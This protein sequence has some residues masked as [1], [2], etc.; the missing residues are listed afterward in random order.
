MAKTAKNPY[1]LD[2][3]LTP[4]VYTITLRPDLKNFTFSGKESVTFKAQKPFSKITLHAAELKIKKAWLCGGKLKAELPAKKISYNEKFETAVFDFGRSVKPGEAGCLCIEFD[5]TLNDKL[6]GFY[7][8]AYEV[9]GE[10]RWGAATQFE[11]TDA[12]RAFPC[13]DEPDFKA[14]FKISL[15]VP[16]E[17]TALSNMP[18]EKEE[19]QPGGL[20]KLDYEISPVM[21][22]Y[23][24]CMVVADLEF[25]E[26]KDK[27]GVPIRIYTVPGK[28]EQ[29]RFALEVAQHC[30]PYFGEWFGIPYMLPK[31]DMVSLPDFASGAME[32][33]GLIT[34]RETA[35]LVDPVNSSAAAR[36]R[37]AEVIDHELAHQWF[38]NLVTME[39]WTDLWLN[40]GFASYM[41]P[42]AV[43]DKFPE[44]KIWD[45]FIVAD[46]L[47]ALGSDALRNTHPIEIPVQDP[48]EIREIFDA[49]TYSKGSSVN[50]M[51]EH[52]LGESV[53][54]KGLRV[55]MKKFAYK[56]ASTIDLW[57]TLEQVSGKPVRA[58]MTNFTRQPGFPVL[59]VENK[60]GSTTQFKINQ[61]RFLFD[62]SK[63]AARTRWQVPLVISR[64]GE[65][66]P[67]IGLLKSSSANLNLGK[68]EGWTKINAG[69]SGF[70]RT[71]YS[72]E[73]LAALAEALEDGSL[74]DPV[75]DALGIL[76]DAH[77]LT[78]AGYLKTSCLLDLLGTVKEEREYN[79]WSIVCGSLNSIDNLL[80]GEEDR[81]RLAAFARSLLTPCL[82]DIGWVKRDSD[83]HSTLLLRS[84][85]IS[86]A[87]HFGAD[88]VIREARALFGRF[89]KTGELEPNLR[90]PV[91]AL[92]AENGGEAEFE[93]LINIYR[94]TK[95]QEEKVRVL[96]ALT[97]FKD[98]HAA[99]KSLEFALSKEVR[100]QDTYN[101]LGGYGSS[102]EVRHQAW[103]FV[104][105]N[106]K[107]LRARYEGGSVAS[108]LGHILEGSVT[109]FNK[110]EELKD[111]ETFFKKNPVAGVERT[112]K[113][114]LEIIRSNIRWASRGSK[115]ASGW[116]EKE[117][118]TVRT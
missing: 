101:V 76:S 75:I 16:Q 86:Q 85:L 1:R 57:K 15:V 24:V 118:L 12:R 70:Y 94:G 49:I 103:D 18:V 7:R 71:A 93:A 95:L 45:Q 31:C 109:G 106:F 58:I 104:K 61:E 115:E 77:A 5:G 53:F 110:P 98:R 35:L 28:K 64:A 14:R 100:N 87:G 2:R 42:K 20:K 89:N 44:W 90:G 105:S 92:T 46:Y 26:G 73:M 27:N 8:T 114:S 36:Q 91:Y 81:D 113:Q 17:L 62:G 47:R 82:D 72:A 111:V 33:W 29:G 97:R 74:P 3:N 21:S 67:W 10:K 19:K 23:L 83:S 66:K 48:A 68:G 65:K 112:M 107:E 55:Y 60:K 6:H 41:G 80:D 52:Y 96:R 37:V 108:L 11:A 54:R 102:R 78:R 63:D 116:L 88:E 39:W 99:A 25:I 59:K 43:D 22:T 38:G 50:R 51:L 9:R 34:Y 117:E 32:N 40:E 69:Q 84:M 30:L 56:N 13:W 79:I 4:L